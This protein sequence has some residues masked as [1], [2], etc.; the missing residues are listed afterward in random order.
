[1][2]FTEGRI[3]KILEELKRKTMEHNMPIHGIK[4]KEC[5]YGEYNL[6]HENDK[7]WEDF[8]VKQIW[9]GRDKHSWF[10][11]RITMPR[12]FTGK[13]VMLKIITDREG[14]DATNPQFI[15]WID[16]DLQHGLDANHTLLSLTKDCKAGEV[17]CVDLYAY[18]GTEEG[19]SRF[20]A[21]LFTLNRQVEKLYYD[22][23]VPLEAACLLQKEDKRRIDTL[24]CLEGA[25]NLLDLREDD[26]VLFYRSV[27]E[28]ILYLEKEFYKSA[29][30]GAGNTT[31]LCVGHT[32]ID[33]A[34]LWSL[35]Q[36]REKVVRSF[37]TVISLM[38]EFPEYIFMS[39]QPQLYQFVKQDQP[40][41]YEEIK[42]MVT[43]GRWEPEG[44]MW[45]EADCN[46]ISGESLIRQIMFGK[47]FFKDE[48]GVDNKI[49]WLPDVFGYSAALPQIMKKSGVSYFMT[50]K[51]SW[52]EFNKLPYD[53]FMWRGIDGTEI[54][55][56][57]VT[58]QEYN[59]KEPRINTTYNGMIDPSHVL[60]CWQRYQQ[61]NISN[62]VLNCFGYGD[63]GGGPTREMLENARR[64]DKGLP[65]MP[66]V[67][68][69]KAIDFF[70]KLEENTL[71]NP[72]LPNWV[73]ELYLEFHRG[74]YTSM[75]RNKRYNRKVEF[76]NQDME[77]LSVMAES[78]TGLK[79]PVKDI[80]DS[81][82]VTLL[83][84]FH[85]II[86]GSSIK[87]VYETSKEQYEQLL[88]SG[89]EIINRSLL[90]ITEKIKINQNSF[91]VFNQ[92]GYLRDDVVTADI[93]EG[94]DNAEIYD[95][96]QLIKS[97]IS[98]DGKL[99][100]FV[101]GLPAKGYKQFMIKKAS[102]QQ[103]T[104][105]VIYQNG[106]E[107]ENKFFDIKIDQD[108]NITT[109]YDKYNKRQ[110][111]KP[112]SR[113]NVLQVFEDKPMDFDAWNL[114]IYYQEKSWEMNEVT[115]IR[116]IEKG[117]VRTIIQIKKTYLKST[118][119][120]MVTMYSQINRI[121]FHTK[122]DWK[123]KQAFVK[124][125]FPVEI[126]SD[127]ATYDIQ[128]GNVER[129]THWN[130]SWD[131]AKFEVCAHKWADLSEG[132]YGV[133]LLNDC[134]YGY[135]I[136]DSVMRL[137]LLKSAIFPNPDADKE[138]HEFTYSIYP[139]AGNFKEAKVDQMAYRVNCPVY[140]LLQKPHEGLLP[141][142]LSFIS[143]DQ[144]NIFLDTIKKSESGKEYIIRMYEN[145][146]QLTK[147]C[148][149]SYHN[150]RSITECDLLENNISEVEYQD[151]QFEFMIK[152]FEIKTFKIVIE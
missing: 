67:H 73:G 14:W 140:C 33:V 149:T 48:F 69:G 98:Q 43:E 49:L 97:Q 95:E 131:L 51:I 25:V 38:K 87:E 70:E 122:I 83:N 99:V 146:N 118:I 107:M 12:E 89:S 128:F 24:T 126:N 119:I 64:L 21:E 30:V 117:P 96:D 85:D 11:F 129:P 35:R 45:V 18:G 105:D 93:P 139:H 141:E 46:L 55:T 138:L 34:W 29:L 36:T 125:A 39:S 142:K 81:W 42:K 8:S 137:S 80:N 77:W 53:T 74:T 7:E 1:M 27:E 47:K 124:A 86:P 121:D 41:L 20:S 22:I 54:L 32:H 101:E 72:K 106:C 91:V 116:L 100:F 66:K 37:S 26:S 50:T 115:E 90:S 15:A 44:S 13:P 135:D 56:Q 130:T 120:Q 145:H 127:K 94:W 109:F 92:L 151:N 17:F 6:L 136:K 78:L 19:D 60:G 23:W 133:A 10:R 143:V 132:G 102:K 79:Y 62:E 71:H 40:E 134:K 104:C 52:N 147:A 9:G 68:I 63:G 84:Q 152:P 103:T 150:F 123:E 110:V 76:M 65:G 3:K 75:A 88:Q 59:E 2:F 28:A 4:W 58:T 108:G 61:K 5:E 144:S 112:N 148:C 111:L 57:F 31:E 114:D 16:G 113:G 82:E